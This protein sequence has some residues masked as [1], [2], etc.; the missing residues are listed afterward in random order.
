VRSDG[1]IGVYVTGAITDDAIMK[2]LGRIGEKLDGC[3]ARLVFIDLAGCSFVD[4][5]IVA[6]IAKIQKYLKSSG[7]NFEVRLSD[8]K[9]QS[10]FKAIG[11]GNIITIC[12][13]S[14]SAST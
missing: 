3:G 4:S 5:R 14:N 12:R 9:L 10:F 7:C 8:L 11:L 1:S 13:P 2:E 6:P